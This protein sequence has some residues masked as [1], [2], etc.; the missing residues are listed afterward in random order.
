[1]RPE[2]VVRTERLHIIKSVFVNPPARNST[3]LSFLRLYAPREV[4]TFVLAVQIEDRQAV[5]DEGD[6]ACDPDTFR[7]RRLREAHS[8]VPLT[9]S[10]QLWRP[11]PLAPCS[12]KK[13]VRAASLRKT[14][15]FS[16][17]SVL[18]VT[19]NREVL[20]TKVRRR[21]N[22]SAGLSESRNAH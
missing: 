12:S 14:V 6:R 2:N 17:E 4:L 19:A 20:G 1:M 16:A 18:P 8:S 5:I 9:L 3:S 21:M 22:A 10:P 13:R 15:W 11:C 7:M